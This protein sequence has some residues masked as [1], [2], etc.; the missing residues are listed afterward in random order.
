MMLWSESEF[1]EF[2]NFQ[3]VDSAHLMILIRTFSYLKLDNSM[4]SLQQLR[5]LKPQ[6]LQLAT[7]Y[8]ARNIRLFGS[9]AR[10]DMRD[11]SDIDFL[12]E[13]DPQRS[14]LDQGGLLM[15]L[16]DLLGCKVD[17]V[18]EHA[19]RPRFREQIKNEII[20]L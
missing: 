12:V 16:Q 11:E 20:V 4:Y 8:G 6:I 19:L 9:V 2:E 15:D 1:T 13:F 17:V 3:N 5:Q 7:C 10:G 18:D 14:L